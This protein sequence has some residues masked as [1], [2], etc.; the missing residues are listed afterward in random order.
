MNISLN[1]SNDVEQNIL[2][3]LDITLSQNKIK[4]EQ[5]FTYSE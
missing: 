4:L 3:Q 2:Q 5:F 1:K